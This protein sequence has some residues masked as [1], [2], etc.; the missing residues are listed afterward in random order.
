MSKSK[1]PLIYRM[2][3]ATEENEKLNY[4]L[5]DPSTHYVLNK[6]YRNSKTGKSSCSVA[7]PFFLF[8]SGTTFG[9]NDYTDD[10]GVRSYSFRMPLL[11][12]DSNPESMMI[13]QKIAEIET[14]FKDHL[15]SEHN[16]PVFFGKGLTYMVGKNEVTKTD[17]ELIAAFRTSIKYKDSSCTS[18]TWNPSVNYD[19]EKKTWDITIYDE[20]GTLLY[21]PEKKNDLQEI[22]DVVGKLS[23][24]DAIIECGYGWTSP[25]IGW[26][27][28]WK[29][30]QVKLHSSNK[31]IDLDNCGDLFGGGMLDGV[32]SIGGSTSS[33]AAIVVPAPAPFATPTPVATQAPAAVEPTPVKTEPMEEEVA[34]TFDDIAEEQAG[35]KRTAEAAVLEETS[36]P[37]KVT[38]VV[39]KVVA[40]PA[41]K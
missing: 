27:F 38:K 31:N 21:H 28:T 17:N 37:K 20:D 24:V 10:A 41:A 35:P 26:G 5:F 14:T 1:T 8:V 29:V 2:T 7:A 22:Y 34:D 6:P 16:K 13:E 33:P 9:I 32:G 19:K 36:A 4:P 25:A 40:K 18:G 15:L 39:K 30:K 3:P 12:N 23:K 11:F